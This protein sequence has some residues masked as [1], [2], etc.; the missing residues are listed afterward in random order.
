M[1]ADDRDLE[2]R[3]AAMR[4]MDR[5]NAPEFGAVLGR[6][7]RRPR[8]PVVLAAALVAAVVILAFG[9]AR[10]ARQRTL[11]E[12]GTPSV[13]TWQSPTAAL[14]ETPELDLVRG[15]PTL[16]SSLLRNPGA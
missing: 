4:S 1:Q 15:V 8:R 10:L 12:R 13:L 6:T 3:F 11:A 9:G 7:V 16:Q 2:R 5:A 14:L